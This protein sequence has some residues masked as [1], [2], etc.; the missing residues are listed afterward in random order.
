MKF[1]Y[2]YIHVCVLYSRTYKGARATCVSLSC[3][4]MTRSLQ[5]TY[6][7]LHRHTCA[8]SQK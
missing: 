7:M 4:K 3:S 2:I 6:Q 1:V 5:L 8:K